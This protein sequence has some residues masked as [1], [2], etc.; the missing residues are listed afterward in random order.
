MRFQ[1]PGGRDQVTIPAWLPGARSHLPA[2][3][4]IDGSPTVV[5][6]AITTLSQLP[7]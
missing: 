1:Q 4:A 2:C 7:H 3:T 6:S 5:T